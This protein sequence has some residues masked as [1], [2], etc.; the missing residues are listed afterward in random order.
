MYDFLNRAIGMANFRQ[1]I[2]AILGE[3]TN[4]DYRQ[5]SSLTGRKREQVV[6]RKYREQLKAAMGIEGSLRALSYHADVL[7]KDKDRTHYH[8][9]YLT[10]HPKGI[11][12]F[13]AASEKVDLFQRVLR[14]QTKRDA[15][16]QTVLFSAE[17]EA[18]QRHGERQGLEI[19]KDYWLKQLTCMAIKYDEAKLANMLESTGWLIGDFQSAFSE[20]LAE[21]KVEN[22]DSVRRRRT[23][24]IH[25]KGGERL[26]RCM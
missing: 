25:F 16:S 10:R 14:I 19:V 23:R 18:D 6:V 15:R 11:V 21:G 3:M 1:Q 2:Q 17:E 12:E 9:V 7:N 4:E 24:P 5:I 26:R 8:M 13:A 22:L 20:L